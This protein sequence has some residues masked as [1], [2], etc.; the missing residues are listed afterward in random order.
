MDEKQKALT[1]IYK[2]KA[3]LIRKL[4]SHTFRVETEEVI[5]KLNT[6]IEDIEKL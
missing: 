4:S 6:L 5:D 2:L 1:E 3:Y